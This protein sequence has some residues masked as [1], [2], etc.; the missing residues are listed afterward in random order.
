MK[1]YNFNFTESYQYCIYQYP[2]RIF[3]NINGDD[4]TPK[5]LEYNENKAIP[6]YCI[7]LMNSFI[8][9]FDIYINKYK[10]I[11]PLKK[12]I[13]YDK[14]AYFID[15]LIADIPVQ[16][17][18]V[19]SGLIDNS[20]YFISDDA[21]NGEA[22]RII[23]DKNLIPNTATP[24]HE[25]FHVFQYNYCNFNNMWFMEGLARWSQNL[26]HTRKMIEEELPQNNDQLSILLDRKH[27]AEYFWR[28]LIKKCNNNSNFVKVLLEQC[29]KEARNK[30]NDDN[31]SKE[32]KKSYLNNEYIFK[33]IISTIEILDED[34]DE[35]LNF[36]IKTLKEYK[37]RIYKGN[38]DF[39]DLAENIEII[40]GDLVIEDTNIVSL[41][42]FNRL[43]K[44]KT[45]KIKNNTKLLEILGFNGLESIQ[46]IEIS[47]NENLEKVYGF[48]KFFN[49]IGVIDGYIKIE[50]NNKLGN[51]KFLYGLKHIGS[52]FCLHDN[53]LKT[54]K[55]SGQQE[56]DKI[57][58]YDTWRLALG[59]NS[60][61]DSHF[62]KFTS[63]DSIIDYVEKYGIV[64]VYAQ[65]YI[66]QKFLFKNRERLKEFGLKFFANDL[67]TVRILL[68]KRQFYEHMIEY[69]LE[70]L[71]PKYYPK[72][73]DI[74][75]P[76]VTKQI[77][78]A[79]GESVR[80]VY[81]SKELGVIASDEVVNKYISGK[82]EYASNI[83]YK[84][85]QIIE[86]ITYEKSFD[87]TYYILNNDTKYKMIDKK[88]EN[89]YKKDFIKIFDSLLPNGG[90]LT[91]CIDY[92]IKNNI[93]KIFEIN[94]RL[95]YTLAR[96]EDDF[97]QM[98]KAYMMECDNEYI[99]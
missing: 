42:S 7:K 65:K 46:N 50:S 97:K 21:M 64:Y 1:L 55:G 29:S 63:V 99:S 84:D 61:L 88:I 26:T 56:K 60:W 58:F 10:F 62:S 85:G 53:S 38:I 54:I 68:D 34:S 35:Q 72:I 80:I 3:Y 2:F 67:K 5:N 70:Y 20:N 93:P 86:D 17:G 19:A 52:S 59:K 71:I 14:G 39:N 28:E 24:I 75:Y 13:F 32:E 82:I 95:G 23:L 31:W 44:V 78:A 74:K 41:N 79:N 27:D 22:I 45:I 87:K 69:N 90:T 37:N 76:C 40:E 94:V 30:N 43:K 89:K 96:N 18:L 98:M 48:F 66:A 51:I 83:F 33:A 81:N 9:A 49:K 15:I 47:N 4:K 77:T 73:E 16:K 8:E 12:G 25:L 57:L 91:C 92:K 6:N 11:N 36:F